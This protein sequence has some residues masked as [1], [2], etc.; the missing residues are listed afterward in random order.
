MV[1]NL[2]LHYNDGNYPG[3]HRQEDYRLALGHWVKAVAKAVREGRLDDA[4][5]AD[6]TTQHFNTPTGDYRGAG[7]LNGPLAGY[8]CVALPPGSDAACSSVGGWRNRVMHEV[9][10]PLQVARLGAVT[11]PLWDLHVGGSGSHQD[12]THWCYSPALVEAVTFELASKMA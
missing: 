11:A 5:L 2:G 7:P 4:V 6:T 12:C 8:P 9:R 1:V 10:G 3:L